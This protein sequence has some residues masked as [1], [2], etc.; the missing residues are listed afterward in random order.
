MEAH[1]EG[2]PGWLLGLG[3][4]KGYIGKMEKKIETTRMGL[5]SGVQCLGFRV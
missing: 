4:Y 3:L 5:G 1:G 2:G